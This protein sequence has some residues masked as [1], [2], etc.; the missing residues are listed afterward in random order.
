[1]IY[2]ADKGGTVTKPIKN[3]TKDFGYK[4]QKLPG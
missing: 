4:D 2:S 3:G 1:M